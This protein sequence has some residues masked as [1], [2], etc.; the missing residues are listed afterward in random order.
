MVLYNA[1][2]ARKQALSF[3]LIKIV[4]HYEKVIFS[5]FKAVEL[6]MCKASSATTMYSSGLETSRKEREKKKN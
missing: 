4:L 3:C 2:H 6:S 1:E 5:R